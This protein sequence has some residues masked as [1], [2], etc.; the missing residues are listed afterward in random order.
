MNGQIN[1]VE[2]VE[3]K[4]KVFAKWYL[5]EKDPFKGWSRDK[6]LKLLGMFN[7]LKEQVEQEGTGV[8]FLKMEGG[9][10][11]GWKLKKH[12]KAWKRVGS[13]FHRINNK[14]MWFPGGWILCDLRRITYMWFQE[15]WID[16]L[17]SISYVPSRWC[18]MEPQ[19]HSW[20]TLHTSWWQTRY[21]F[22]CRVQ[23]PRVVL[24]LVPL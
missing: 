21:D 11:N 16:P 6:D 19:W 15:N 10:R 3:W 9:R 14:R 24:R 4:A 22:H 8:Q 20:Q 12:V 2:N 17:D 13:T 7:N 1:G 23:W 5:K 18:S